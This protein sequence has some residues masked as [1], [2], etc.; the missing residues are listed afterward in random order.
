MA[1]IRENQQ[2]KKKTN[3]REPMC[4][5]FKMLTKILITNRTMN[6]TKQFSSKNY[7]LFCFF[8]NEVYQTR[9]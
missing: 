8:L 4:N 6:Q 3:V 7:L 2:F 1:H 9:C 5:C